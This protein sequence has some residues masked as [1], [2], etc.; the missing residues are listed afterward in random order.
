MGTLQQHYLP[1]EGDKITVTLPAERTRCEIIKVVSDEACIAQLLSFTTA[2]EHR[3]TKG[4]KIACRFELGP[5]DQP[6]W[7]YVP[8]EQMDAEIAERNAR[9]A[10]QN[11]EPLS[12][13]EPKAVEPEPKRTARLGKIFG[14]EVVAAVQKRPKAKRPSERAA[15]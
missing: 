14:P 5:M 3:L 2:K 6:Q 8:Q 12:D 11:A 10:E 7:V 9:W 1:R 15:E 13:G 4:D